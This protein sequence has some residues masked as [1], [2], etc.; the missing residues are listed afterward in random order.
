MSLRDQLLEQQKRWMEGS[1]KE[2]SK[3]PIKNQSVVQ[4]LHHSSMQD[5][6]AMTAKSFGKRADLESDCPACRCLMLP[7][8]NSPMLL[9]PCGHSICQEC[10]QYSTKCPSCKEGITAQAV[11]KALERMICSET[12][13]EHLLREQKV[14][15]QPV[16]KSS[17]KDVAMRIKVLEAEK[18]EMQKTQKNAST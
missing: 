11:N 18:K 3:E 16:R 9:I 13:N 1:K 15:L 10:G 8:G 12:G 4:D 5:K 7:P 6:M 17:S 2:P 14:A